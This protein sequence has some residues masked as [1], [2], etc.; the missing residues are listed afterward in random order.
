LR[1]ARFTVKRP[2]APDSATISGIS[3][4]ATF[5]TAGFAVINDEAKESLSL[6]DQSN[7][8]VGRSGNRLLPGSISRLH[9]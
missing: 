4:A 1:R 6:E 3:N 7:H 8:E 9:T 5:S 2:S